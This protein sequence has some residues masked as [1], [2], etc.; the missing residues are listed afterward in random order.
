MVG[1]VHRRIAPGGIGW[2]SVLFEARRG[3][4]VF[5]FEHD[6]D[7]PAQVTFHRLPIAPKRRDDLDHPVAG[8]RA[9][10]SSRAQDA[11]KIVGAARRKAQ[12]VMRHAEATGIGNR[13]HLDRRLGAV[14]EGVEHLRVHA[15]VLRLCEGETVVLPN[16]VRRDRVI[17][18]Q[19]FG[20]LARRCH[21]KAGRTLSNPKLGRAASGI[22][23]VLRLTVVARLKNCVL[24]FAQQ[25]AAVWCSAIERF[26]SISRDYSMH[27]CGI[28]S[29]RHYRKTSP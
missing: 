6:I 20:A 27:A 26:R 4:V 18:W 25:V 9:A 11:S 24:A 17:G 19:I 3:V 14:E 2:Q 1:L 22:V 8:Q 5:R 23:C 13:R 29:S 15:G 28:L 12:A 21:R 7:A 16:A 10:K